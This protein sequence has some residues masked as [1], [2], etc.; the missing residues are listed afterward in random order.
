MRRAGLDVLL[1]QL[2]RTQAEAQS[3]PRRRPRGKLLTAALR[4][5][6]RA[7]RLERSLRQCL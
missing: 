4:L 3:L 2:A 5:R 6:R 7:K 1:D